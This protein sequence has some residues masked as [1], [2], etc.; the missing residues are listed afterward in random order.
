MSR[1]RSLLPLL[2][3]LACK[4]GPPPGPM[5][6]DAAAIVERYLDEKLASQPEM[7]RYLGL[8]EYDGKVST[9]SQ[10]EVDR[11]IAAARAY[12][13]L[14]QNLD[15]TKVVDPTRLDL[16]LTRLDAESTIFR[17]GTLQLHRRIL[18]YNGLY[19]VSGYLVR[20]YAP[21]PKRVAAMLDH[22][23]GVNGQIDGILALLDPVQIK[24][25]L[26]TAQK[27][28]GGLEEYYQGDVATLTKP[29][30]DVDP[31][32][33][34]R[35]QATLQVTLQRLRQIS[36]WIKAHQATASQDFALGEQKFLELIATN[37]GLK[38][39]LP[40]LKAMAQADFQ[41]NYDAFVA[42][43]QRIEPKKSVEQVAAMIAAERLRSDQ[44]LPT[45]RQ[46]LEQLLAFIDEQPIITI[47][48]QERATVVESPPFMR[49]NSAFL[50]GPGPFEK[51]SGG[52]YYISPPDPTWPKEMQEAY[53]PYPADLL[54]TSIHEV[55]PGHFVQGLQVRRAKSRAQKMLDSYAFVEGWAHYSEQMM[56]DAGF[57]GGDPR[58]KLG[59]LSN[60]LLRNCR[61]LAAI[62]LH[63]GGMTVAEAD[64][65]FQDKC[66][67]DP[68][69]AI[70]Q[71]YRG[72]F[73]P[74]YLSYTL[75]KLQILELR[76]RYFQKHGEDLRG[77][78][79]W[80]LSYGSS[81]VALIGERL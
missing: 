62:G 68:G 55:Y 79:D 65:L 77:F 53:L 50:D 44:V 63:T 69:N 29:A 72:T 46:Q 8:H 58:V 30:R 33:E 9:Y 13:A 78:H 76:D 70:Q 66:F 10:E 25:H 35:Y 71:A 24:T 5:G 48:S 73:D 67:I 32:L 38:I 14:V 4:S 42:T 17:L 18:S 40:E 51:A 34:A 47:G 41:R 60:A 12:L 64:K 1:R 52:F 15:R 49:W 57:G 59:Q 54:A 3:V 61:F 37:E 28:F 80:L 6:D 45:A 19:D 22:L 26:E 23:E 2:L 21:L 56:L 20:D 16:E 81:P 11:K 7:G 31:A 39:T 36:E 74:G 75:G 27:A 43:A